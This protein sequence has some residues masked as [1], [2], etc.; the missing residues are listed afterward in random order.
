M[1]LRFPFKERC[2]L[3]PG[4]IPGWMEIGGMYKYRDKAV[5]EETD[6]ERAGSL[7]GWGLEIGLPVRFIGTLQG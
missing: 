6:S 3:H 7:P 4:R 2:G 5:I 1:I